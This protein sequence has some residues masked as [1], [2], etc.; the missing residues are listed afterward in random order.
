[1]L[2]RKVGSN[3]ICALS[4]GHNVR[5][6]DELD[7]DECQRAHCK[8]TRVVFCFNGLSAIER[9]IC[10]SNL[11]REMRFNGRLLNLF[12]LL[13]I[14]HRPAPHTGQI[15]KLKVKWCADAEPTATTTISL[16]F[17]IWITP[18]KTLHRILQHSTRQHNCTLF[19]RRVDVFAKI[20]AKNKCN[21]HDDATQQD[22]NW[23][24]EKKW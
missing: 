23:K 20:W 1:M 4:I 16:Y 7:L 19:A 6:G 8:C 2:Y 11:E 13:H 10:N 3:A 14:F 17:S 12:K 24:R 22:R 5:A 15:N 9:N 21:K 18:L